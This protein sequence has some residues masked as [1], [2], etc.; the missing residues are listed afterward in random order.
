MSTLRSA[1]ASLVVALCIGPCT[2]TSGRA[3]EPNAQDV[4]QTVPQPGISQDLYLEVFINDEPTGLVA[5]FRQREDGGLSA[6]P[7]E[8]ADVGLK[9]VSDAKDK[10]GSIR[11]DRL[12]NV[13]YRIDAENQRLYVTTN[14]TARAAKVVDLNPK[15]DED[16]P[17]P[18]SSYGAVLNYSL[19]ASSNN[20]F[21]GS[22]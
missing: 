18:Q 3:Q 2:L 21:K 7:Q 15:S 12:P 11:V 5:A 13:Q 4:E 10:D 1:A 9:P 8:L 17:K 14:D 20:L 6:S 22:T 19:F 16:R